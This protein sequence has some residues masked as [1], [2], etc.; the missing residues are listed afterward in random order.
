[1]AATIPTASRV[2]DTA[3]TNFA[4]SVTIELAGQVVHVSANTD[5]A[6]SGLQRILRSYLRDAVPD[7]RKG[8]AVSFRDD[9]TVRISAFL[10]GRRPHLNGMLAGPEWKQFTPTEEEPRQQRPALK[11]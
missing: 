9:G 2:L 6:I 10:D 7:A 1:M 5:A 11:S 3:S 4:Q 8:I